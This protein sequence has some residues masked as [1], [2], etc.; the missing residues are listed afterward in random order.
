MNLQ[1]APIGIWVPVDSSFITS[2]RWVPSIVQSILDR[3]ISGT[4][5][6]RFERDKSDFVA[7]TLGEFVDFLLA[8]SQGRYYNAHF[9]R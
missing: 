7:C 9:R 6:V 1:D 5:E 4:L 8:G 3:N 2:V